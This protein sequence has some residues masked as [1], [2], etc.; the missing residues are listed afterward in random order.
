[1]KD[2]LTELC[3]TPYFNSDLQ[4]YN[5]GIISVIEYVLNNYTSINHD[6]LRK[7]R[8]LIWK[9]SKYLSG[10]ISSEIPYEVTFALSKALREWVDKDCVI[11]TAL[12]DDR[13]FHFFPLDPWKETKLLLPDFEYSEFDNILIQIALPKLYKHIPLYNVAL[14]HELGHFVDTYY[15]ITESTFLTNPI[16]PVADPNQ[17][18][19]RKFIETRHRSEFFADLFA[20]CYTGDA[21]YKFLN[22]VALNAPASETHPATNV[23]IDVAQQFLQGNNHPVIDMYQNILKARGL[24][25]LN[26]KFDSPTLSESF[27]NIRPYAIQNDREL[28]GIMPA[29]WELLEGAYA[30]TNPPWS[31]LSEHEITILI[32]D[33]T[34]KS[35]RNKAIMDKWE[36]G[37]TK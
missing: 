14:Y 10:S 28:H 7:I 2:Y 30:S 17:Q 24:Q 13:D 23:R 35:I 8:E 20:A 16:P 33:L 34:E 22:D 18:K 15:K 5:K 19:Y 1:M 4:K 21:N 11:T 25:E 36:D 29:S 12:V 37:T 3:A 9:A 32:N 6:Y 27:N 31:H 26:I